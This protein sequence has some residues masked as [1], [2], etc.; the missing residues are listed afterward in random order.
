MIATA[1]APPKFIANAT[2]KQAEKATPAVI[3]HPPITVNTPVMRNT[4]LSLLQAL[5]ANDEPIATMKV[6]NVVDKGNLSEVPTAM[7]S[8]DMTKLTE[9]RHIS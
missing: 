3:N 4:A 2:K 5:S 1:T 6:T 9:A 8:D 7:S